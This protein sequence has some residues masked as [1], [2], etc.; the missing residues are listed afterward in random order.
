MTPEER[1]VLQ[2]AINRTTKLFKN[3]RTARDWS[4]NIL[5]GSRNLTTPNVWKH[6]YAW[7][8]NPTN[9]S[10]EDTDN[11]SIEEYTPACIAPYPDGMKVTSFKN[12]NETIIR[13]SNPALYDDDVKEGT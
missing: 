10:E 9:Y 12:G 11:L 2:V 8:A 13:V 7:L 5:Q 4:D 1:T 3:R 6:Y